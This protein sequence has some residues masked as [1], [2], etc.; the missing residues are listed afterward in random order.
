[1][2]CYNVACNSIPYE[3]APHLVITMKSLHV[4]GLVL[5][6][7][8]ATMVGCL[9]FGSD[10]EVLEPH[11]TAQHL[12]QITSM[13]GVVF[14]AG[15]RGAAYLYMGSGIDDA[16]AAKIIIPQDRRAEFLTN[17]V[18]EQG[19]DEVPHIRIG[20]GRPWW[21]LDQITDRVDRTLDLPNAEYLECTLGTEDGQTVVYISWMST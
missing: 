19:D 18:F 1:M 6:L 10:T 7:L 12:Q 3:L 4:F 15:A 14:P 9:E 5:G 20:S 16:L 8:I 11:V 17:V 21:K 2:L 13:T